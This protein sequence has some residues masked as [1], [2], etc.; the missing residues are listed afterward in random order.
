MFTLIAILTVLQSG[1]HST[2][3]VLS[4]FDNEQVCDERATELVKY[5]VGLLP[6][7]NLIAEDVKIETKCVTW[8]GPDDP[9]PV[10]A[11]PFLHKP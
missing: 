11:G 5:V 10:I 7:R 2:F 9:P 8:G 6:E 3:K 4:P 1:N